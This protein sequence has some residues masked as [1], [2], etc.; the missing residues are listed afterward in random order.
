[1][2][3]TTYDIVLINQIIGFTGF[4]AR[5]VA[6]FQALLGPSGTLAYRDTT[7]SPIHYR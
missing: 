3:L 7:F 1:M 5:A 6:V 2:G 4:Q